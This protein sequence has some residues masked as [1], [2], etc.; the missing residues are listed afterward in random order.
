MLAV[1]DALADRDHRVLWLH[2]LH[3]GEELRLQPFRARGR[4]ARL[5]WLRLDRL[6]RS[7]STGR[8]RTINPRLFGVLAQVQRHFGGRRLELVSGYRV[9]GEGEE[10]DSYHHVGRAADIRIEG[11]PDRELFEYCRT[12]VDVGCGYYPNGRHVHIDVRS[13]PG[14]WVDLGHRRYVRDPRR[15]LGRN[16][17]PAGAGEEH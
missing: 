7:A 17:A 1:G 12:L 5:A 16:P 9:P 3:T 13:R 4:L 6:F 2:N 10:L 11:V 15:W 8:R 14:I